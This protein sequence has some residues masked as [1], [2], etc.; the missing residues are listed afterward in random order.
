MFSVYLLI[1]W[2]P[3]AASGVMLWLSWS[4]GILSRPLPVAIWFALAL[5]FQIVGELF[6]PLWAIGLVCQAVL[7]IYLAIRIK[8]DM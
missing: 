8:L 1:F 6:S 4:N 5:F 2:I 7:A 3:S